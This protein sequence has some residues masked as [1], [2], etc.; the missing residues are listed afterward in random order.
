MINYQLLHLLFI[1][2]FIQIACSCSPKFGLQRDQSAKKALEKVMRTCRTRTCKNE[3]SA[4]GKYNAESESKDDESSEQW[5]TYQTCVEDCWNSSRT[6]QKNEDAADKFLE[7]NNFTVKDA[8]E[9]YNKLNPNNAVMLKIFFWILSL[10]LYNPSEVH[11]AL[12]LEMVQVIWRHGHRTPTRFIASDTTNRED[13]W[14]PG[15]R[16]LTKKGMKQQFLLGRI[17]SNRYMNEI[18]VVDKSKAWQQIYIRSSNFN[19]TILSAL[20]NLAAFMSNVTSLQPRFNEWPKRWIP[21]PIHTEDDWILKPLSYCPTAAKSQMDNVVLTEEY[22]EIEENNTEFFK[23]LQNV[24]GISKINLAN[25]YTVHDS[26]QIIKEGSPED[27]EPED[28]PWPAWVN[29]EIYQRIDYLRRYGNGYLFA[30]ENVRRLRAGPLLQEIISRMRDKAESLT[31]QKQNSSSWIHRLKYYAYSAHDLNILILM[32]MFG[33]KE[34]LAKNVD[35]PGFASCLVFELWKTDDNQLE[36]KIFLR[37]GP[38]DSNFEQIQVQGCPLLPNGCPLNLFEEINEKYVVHDWNTECG[39]SSAETSYHSFSIVG[40][41]IALKNDLVIMARYFAELLLI[42]LHI[43]H[44]SSTPTLELVQVIWRHGHRTPVRRVTSLKANDTNKWIPDLGE[45]TKK[46]MKQQFLLGTI[47]A[48]RYMNQIPLIETNTAWQHIYIRSS[49]YNRTIVSALSNLAGFM[50]NSTSGLPNV[51]DWPQKWSPIPVHTEEEWKLRMLR[52]CPAAVEVKKEKVIAT[53]EYQAYETNNTEFFK[54]LRNMT[55]IPNIN[56]ENIYLI[57][58]SL[59]L[60]KEGSPEDWVPEDHPWPIWATEDVYEKIKTLRQHGN[61]FLFADEEIRRLRGGP[62]LQEIIER[63]RQKEASLTN[64]NLISPKWIRNLKYY[65]YSAHDLNILLLLQMFKVEEWLQKS[66]SM[67]DFASCLSIELWRTDN[68]TMEVKVFQRL[69]PTEM[70]FQPVQVGGC[71]KLPS[72]C[73]LEQF[74]EVFQKYFIK[75][76]WINE[77]TAQSA[78]T[79]SLHHSFLSA[80]VFCLI[81]WILSEKI[82][83]KLTI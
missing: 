68:N 54:F 75:N 21:I 79:S 55:G 58:D 9:L 35:M 76:S 8:I 81:Y 2:L 50:H 22:Q 59:Q 37:R 11:S 63:M 12:T 31:N 36:V 19:R 53:A 70:V 51:H 43:T 32:Q 38:L 13:T 4:L 62:L 77:C 48:N 57:D 46:G 74:E 16:E 80:G 42:L 67:P 44:T 72:A 14:I 52:E 61:G 27:W 23:F 78:A 65:A 10:E 24:T 5:N 20:S 69:G 17:L 64:K 29:E 39:L 15:P 71:P 56:L 41:C 28:H 1:F 45:L 66:V 34:W 25:I 60:I 82:F 3:L 30:N 47:L 6:V 26:L 49:N 33:V 40:L 73:P 7:E 83:T 18:P